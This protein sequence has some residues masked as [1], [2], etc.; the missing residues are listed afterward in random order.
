MN[1]TK[2]YPLILAVCEWYPWLE[3]C[4]QAKLGTGNGTKV[5]A[6]ED[7]DISA[8]NL[9]RADRARQITSPQEQAPCQQEYGPQ[10]KGSPKFTILELRISGPT[11]KL[12]RLNFSRRLSRPE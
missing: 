5:N 8:L 3:K 1:D 12:P 2:E 10:N 6:A 7:P 4:R 9:N 11:S